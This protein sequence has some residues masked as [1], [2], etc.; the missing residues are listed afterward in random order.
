MKRRCLLTILSAA[1]LALVFA[2]ASSA[3][4][5]AAGINHPE[6]VISE[7]SLP[8]YSPIARTA[9][10]TGDVTVTLGIRKNGSIDC[11]AVTSG[12]LILHPIVLQSAQQS[13]FACRNCSEV[14]TS[15]SMIYTFQL[16]PLSLA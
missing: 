16:K 11:A 5:S 6:I 9:H 15:Y 10:I 12:P 8:V 2:S 14:V 4:D 3:R 7:L 1:T 13:Q